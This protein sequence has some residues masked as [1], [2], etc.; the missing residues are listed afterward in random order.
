MCGQEH[1]AL[2]IRCLESFGIVF[3]KSVLPRF[4]ELLLHTT[5]AS[6]CLECS[7]SFGDPCRMKSPNFVS[8]C[9][10]LLD[11]VPSQP[12]QTSYNK[13]PQ[14]ESESAESVV[15]EA[16]SFLLPSDLWHQKWA[17]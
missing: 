17:K 14:S 1:G 3:A 11:P 16:P 12:A 4:G 13:Y 8:I 6:I 15:V 7:H 10:I 9:P 2:L 5:S